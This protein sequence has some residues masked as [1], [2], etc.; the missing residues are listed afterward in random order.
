MGDCETNVGL[1]VPHILYVY[2]IS[3]RLAGDS[4]AHVYVLATA[5]KPLEHAAVAG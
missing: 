5:M 3:S 1:I 2:Q 4:I